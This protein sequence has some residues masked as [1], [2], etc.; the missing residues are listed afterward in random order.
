M[1]IKNP[2]DMSRKIGA[3]PKALPESG[4]FIGRGPGNVNLDGI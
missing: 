4:G 3:H 2:G 1:F